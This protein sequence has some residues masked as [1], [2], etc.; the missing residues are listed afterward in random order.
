MK[1]TYKGRFRPTNYKKYQG[2]PTNIIY[3]SG[4]ELR[5][6]KYLDTNPSVLEWSSEEICIP[7]I[8]PI[9]NR[10]HRYFPDFKVKIATSMGGTKTMI[11]EIKPHA[12]TIQPKVQKRKTRKYITEVMT[13]GVNEAKWKSARQWCLD[14]KYEFIIMD[15]Y[16]LGIKDKY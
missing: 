9:D 8:S 5:F 14:R 4:W 1:T 15:E 7:Y 11:V 10:P 16:M 3:R 6:M 2:D 13:W 12:Q